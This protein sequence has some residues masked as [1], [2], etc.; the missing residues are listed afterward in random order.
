MTRRKSKPVRVYTEYPA[1]DFEFV[2]FSLRDGLPGPVACAQDGFF[3]PA[4]DSSVGDK[5]TRIRG[6]EADAIDWLLVQ[7]AE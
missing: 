2:L 4:L 7:E 1:A 5:W 3:W 6:T